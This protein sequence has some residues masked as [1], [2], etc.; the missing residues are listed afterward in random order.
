[1]PKFSTADQVRM[2]DYFSTSM[3]LAEPNV[4]I[5]T[6]YTLVDLI[7]DFVF[8]ELHTDKLYINLSPL[9]QGIQTTVSNF[10]NGEDENVILRDFIFFNQKISD[11]K[12]T[13]F[14]SCILR[15][16]EFD[17]F[18][19]SIFSECNLMES[20][21]KWN[22]REVEFL[23]CILVGSHFKILPLTNVTFRETNI[24]SVKFEGIDSEGKILFSK[25]ILDDSHFDKCTKGDDCIFNFNECSLKNINIIDCDFSR[26]EFS[27]VNF[28]N[29]I[30]EGTND[31]SGA[32]LS[33]VNFSNA[34]FEG[35]NDFSGANLSNVNFSNAIFEGRND[36]SGANIDGVTFSESQMQHIIF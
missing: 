18:T 2:R 28:S 32:N 21:F 31:F 24:S 34:I 26:A 4:E 11:I 7:T 17:V 13:T 27:N 6:N 5:I 23:K 1:M 20:N 30:F 3:Q 8:K 29:A 10:Y 19:K 33:N 36:F 12:N 9:L 35:T 14:I 22:L 15:R 16:I 25:C